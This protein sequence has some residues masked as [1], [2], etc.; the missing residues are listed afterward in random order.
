MNQN[1]IPP[2]VDSRVPCFRSVFSPNNDV[3]HSDA[4]RT[5]TICYYVVLSLVAENDR[6]NDH[7]VVAQR[8]RFVY[9]YICI[10]GKSF[11]GYIPY[12]PEFQ[13][14]QHQQIILILLCD[15]KLRVLIQ[16]KVKIRK[17]AA[18]SYLNQLGGLER[19]CYL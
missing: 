12:I 2:V 4:R 7:L 10:F 8:K 6:M 15:Y 16:Y 14:T 19:N 3:D 17:V 11:V 5:D 13:K 9:I 18:V 1:E